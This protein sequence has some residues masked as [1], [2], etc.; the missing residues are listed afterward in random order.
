MLCV[1]F[2]LKPFLVVHENLEV[3]L[4]VVLNSIC[5]PDFE[6]SNKNGV[7]TASK[8][9]GFS[10]PDPSCLKYQFKEMLVFSVTHPVKLNLPL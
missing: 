5:S 6:K 3:Y 1:Y 7:Q 9:W 8:F 2:P 10:F 4:Q